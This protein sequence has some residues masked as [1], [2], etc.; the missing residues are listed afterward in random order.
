[1]PCATIHLLL[2][3]RVLSDWAE[4]PAHAPVAAADPEIRTAFLHG[5]LAP[6]MGFIPGVDRFVSDLAHF[7]YPA[8]LTR[9]LFRHARCSI[10]EA[11]AWGWTAHVLG[12]VLLH[13]LVGRGVGEILYGDKG[14]RVD[15]AENV[16]AHVSLEVGI[17]I[18]FLERG[19]GIPGPPSS[20]H[21]AGSGLLPVRAALI[22]TYGLRWDASQLS[23]DHRLAVRMTRWWPRV[24][25]SLRSVPR[26]VGG[27]ASPGS[28]AHGFLRP[29]RPNPWLV[30]EVDSVVE[31]FPVAF[32]SLTR[33]AVHD[34]ENLNLETGEP[35]GPGVGH[36]ASDAVVRRLS[37]VRRGERPG[38]SPVSILTR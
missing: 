12:D 27:V 28:A 10:D 26:A 23:R 1:M 15:A 33:G 24:L 17:D 18:A 34:W 30:S 36:A 14:R 11:F 9:A 16:A 35:A 6:D 25:R 20:P 19:V 21:S 29:T 4:H 31:R 3:D 8:D 13:P 32:R 37:L 38:S 7:H 5:S 2:A 22:D